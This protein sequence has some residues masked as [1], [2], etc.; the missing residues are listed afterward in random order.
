MY[1]Y[2]L[3]PYLRFELLGLLN[4]LKLFVV[5]LLR[6]G[7]STCSKKAHKTYLHILLQC[8]IPFLFM[9][10]SECLKKDCFVMCLDYIIKL[11]IRDNLSRI[12]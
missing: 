10:Y 5:K 1:E 3:R 6:V 9:F 2:I 4:L 7:Y 11:N 8:L 12:L